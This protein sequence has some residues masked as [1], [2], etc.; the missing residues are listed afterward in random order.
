M[1]QTVSAVILD[2]EGRVL[3]LK[4]SSSRKAYPNKWNTISGTIENESPKEAILREISEE[5]GSGCSLELL[6]EGK[7]YKDIQVEG[8]WIVYP[9]LFKYKSGGISLN[10]EHSEYNWF[11]RDELKKLDLVPAALKDL[12]TFKL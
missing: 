10:K 8:Q 5:L 11:R 1:K 9:F 12:E 7:C 6:E 3:L 2:N 4:R